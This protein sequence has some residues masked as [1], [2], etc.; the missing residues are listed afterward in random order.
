[1]RSEQAGRAV[2]P[3]PLRWSWCF[4][5]TPFIEKLHGVF[6]P[7]HDMHDAFNIG[8]VWREKIPHVDGTF[9]VIPAVRGEL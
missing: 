3:D 5:N 8:Y 1:M 2:R 6:F 9:A 4:E 7:L